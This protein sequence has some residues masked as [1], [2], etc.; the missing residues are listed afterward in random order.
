MHWFKLLVI[1]FGFVMLALIN[2]PQELWSFAN[3]ASLTHGPVVGAVTDTTAR[4]F[5]R[6]SGSAEVKIRYGHAEDLSDAVES[7]AQQT[8]AEH[9]F[10]TII[11][12]TD[13]TPMTVYSVDV[14][15]DGVPQLSVPYSHFK[16][17]PVPGSNV[18]FKFVVLTD[19]G[20]LPGR[21]DAQATPTFLNADAEQPDFVLIG[22][23]FDHSNPDVPGDDVTTRAFKRLMFKRLYTPD[24]VMGDFVN[25]ILRHYPVVH[26]WDDHDYG[27]DN[28]DKTYP[29]KQISLDVLQEYFPVYPVSQYGD[30]QQFTYARADFFILDSRSQ[31]DPDI[32]PDD[33]NKSMLDGDHLGQVGQW[34]WLKKSLSASTA[35]W[36]FIISPVTFNPTVIKKDSWH[37]FQYE[38]QKLVNFIKRK[39]MRGVV[40]ISGDWHAGG[41][42][43][44]ANADFPELAVPPANLT[45]PHCTSGGGTGIWSNGY[46]AYPGKGNQLECDGYGVVSVRTNPDR[47]FFAVKNEWGKTKLKMSIRP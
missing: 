1:C 13:L 25:L 30:W 22:G 7:V 9:D 43:N 4:V 20:E 28:S 39:N 2:N 29:H 3:T 26:H 16:T 46:W 36:K 21:L 17:F 47:V 19:F 44:G 24:A 33:A 34:V 41:L 31:R 45:P 14:V 12:L 35:T 15:V 38:R 5:V 40:F 6:T 18:S 10:T 27:Q 23:D 32:D 11:P 37:A 42:D 8:V